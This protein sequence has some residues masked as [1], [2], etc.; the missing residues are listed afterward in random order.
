LIILS[1][2]AI[3]AFANANASTIPTYVCIDDAYAEWYFDKFGVN[4]DRSLSLPAQHALQGHP[5]SPRLWEEFINKILIEHLHL[6]STTHERSIYSGKYKDNLI[7][8]QRQVDDI[9]VAA[10]TTKLAQEIILGFACNAS[11]RPS[12]IHSA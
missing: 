6:K 8:I 11:Y 10:P 4:L 2:D 9:A 5:K 1:T 3:I 7:L 12:V